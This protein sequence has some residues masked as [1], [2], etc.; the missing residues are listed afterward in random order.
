MGWFGKLAFGYMGLMVGGP[1]GAVAG[2]A[3]GHHLLDKQAGQT[4]GRLTFMKAE[5]TQAA[6]FVSMFSILGKLAKID[7]VV[8]KAEIAV[9]EDFINQLNMTETEKEFARKVFNEAKDSEYSIGDFAAQFY[10]ISGGQQSVLISYLDVL[11]RIAA[12][13]N[14]LH[15]AEESALNRVKEIFHISDQ[16]FNNIKAVYFK[17]VD[18]YYQVLNCTPDST[19][20]ELKTNYKKLVKDF[21][22]DTIVSKGLPEEFTEF[23]TRRFQEIQEAYDTIRQERKL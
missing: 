10:Q 4:G 16:Q 1:L 23:A 22:P 2:A 7:G 11:F 21:H 8:T 19:D 18:G 13:D 20:R 17:D 15:P 6:Y 3:L 9:I 5:Q 14:R 12:A